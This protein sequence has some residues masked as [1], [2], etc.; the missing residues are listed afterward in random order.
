MERKHRYAFQSFRIGLAEIIEP[1]VVSARDRRSQLR[2]HIVTHHDAQ[3]DRRIERRDVQ[4]FPV[5]RL[6]LRLRVET[7]RAV[8]GDLF[9]D[10][11]RVEYAATITW[12]VALENLP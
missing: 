9:V 1:I 10:A 8:V 7:T 12:F 6:Q 4:S 2:V 11:R 5:H 3:T